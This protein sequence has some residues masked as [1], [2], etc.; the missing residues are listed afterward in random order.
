MFFCSCSSG[1]KSVPETQILKNTI[2]KEKQIII[3]VFFSGIGKIGF[4][5]LGKATGENFISFGNP[6]KKDTIISKSLI[7]DKPIQFNFISMG[8]N[9]QF[10]NFILLPGDTID[11]KVTNFSQ[12]AILKYSRFTG[13]V[14]S[15][16]N[17][18]G[19]LDFIHVTPYEKTSQKRIKSIIGDIETDYAKSQDAINTLYKKNR[20][21]SLYKNC[22]SDFNLVLKYYKIAKIKFKKSDPSLEINEILG[23]HYDEIQNNLSLFS[24]ISSNYNYQVLNNLI[25]Y[26]AY[27]KGRLSNNFWNYFDS[28]DDSLKLTSLYRSYLLSYLSNDPNIKSTGMLKETIKEI[29]NRGIEDN[30]FDSLIIARE[31]TELLKST[32]GIG[33]QNISGDS[34]DYFSII[35]SLKENMF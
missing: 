31:K 25:R 34:V 1:Y 28:I 35:N 14:D 11:L 20:I 26:K 21:D 15:I 24:R 29:R 4:N 2:G 9:E 19:Y 16:F 13:F 12:L 30:R 17:I 22:L 18:Q 7:A 27:K 10:K 5:Y 3:N 23:K 6:A 32:K 8:A 33:M